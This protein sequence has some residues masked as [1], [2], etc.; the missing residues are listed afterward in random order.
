MWPPKAKGIV[1]SIIKDLVPGRRAGL[2]C[3]CCS[4]KQEHR[5][6]AQPHSGS[7]IPEGLVTNWR[8]LGSNDQVS[9]GLE[10]M[11]GEGSLAWS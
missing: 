2:I 5:R 7:Y 8:L 4:V 3:S 9:V 1:G 11:V 6:E 10:F